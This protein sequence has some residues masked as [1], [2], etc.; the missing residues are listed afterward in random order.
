MRWRCARGRQRGPVTSGATRSRFAG[1]RTVLGWSLRAFATYPR[2]APSCSSPG[3]RTPSRPRGRGR[4][5]GPHR[6]GHRGTRQTRVVWLHWLAERSRQTRRHRAHPRRRP[7]PVSAA[8]PGGAGGRPPTAGRARPPRR[9]RGRHTPTAPPRGGP[10]TPT[11]V[12]VQT[13]RVPGP[14]RCLAANT[15]PAA[16]V[17][18]R[19][20][21][22]CSGSLTWPCGGCRATSATSRSPTARLRSA[23]RLVSSV[24]MRRSLSDGRP[25]T[26]QFLQ[27][28]SLLL[29][30]ERADHGYELPAVCA[31]AR[32]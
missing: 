29:L 22:A 21:L 6:G 24:T 17:V 16:R 28:C 12:A 20:G 18:D 15:A 10:W 4:G 2:S 25:G 11:L 5:P 8:D 14:V 31:P 7:T 32:R 23:A 27:P 19:H 9:P 1:E 26:A 30:A 3:L 13:P